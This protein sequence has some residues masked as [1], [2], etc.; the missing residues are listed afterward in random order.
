MVKVEEVIAKLD[1]VHSLYFDGAYKRKVDK[2]A[3]GVVIYDKEGRKVFGKGLMLENI[4]FN[5]ETEYAALSL[6]LEWCLNLGIKC[7]N[8]FGD[9]LLLVKQVHGTWACSNQGLSVQ[10]CR[11]KELLKGC[12]VSRLLHVPRKENQEADALSS[13]QLQGVTIGTVALQQPKFQGS[14]CMLDI[15]HLLDTSECLNG[16]SKGQRQWL[17]FVVGISHMTSLAGKYFKQLLLGLVYIE[18]YN[19]GVKAAIDAN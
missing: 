7:L 12:E 18:M 10:L 17:V 6:G 16:L 4:H 5:N 14:N 2:A 13:E 19:I 11:I 9:A 8:A 3:V 1:E 15:L